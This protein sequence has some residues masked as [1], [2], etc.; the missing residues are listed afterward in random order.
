MD[1]VT[2]QLLGD[3]DIIQTEI[4]NFLEW[5]GISVLDIR[6]AEVSPEDLEKAKQIGIII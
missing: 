1:V 3:G 4:V 6:T 5:S 2:I